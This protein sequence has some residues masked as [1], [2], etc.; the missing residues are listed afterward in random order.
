M[1]AAYN[2]IM[3]M[4]R[5]FLTGGIAAIV[6]VGVFINLLKFDFNIAFAACSSFLLAAI[7]NYHLTSRFVFKT[8][9]NHARFAKFFA[10]ALIGLSINV[11]ATLFLA[12]TLGLTAFLSK[13]GGIGIAFL[14]N[15]ALNAGFVFNDPARRLKSRPDS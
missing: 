14:A 13:A 2:R 15:F 9:L 5:Y 4:S 6:D 11:G 3:H 10:F 1:E 12:K 7:A 8:Q